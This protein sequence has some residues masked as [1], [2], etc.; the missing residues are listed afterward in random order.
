[1]AKDRKQIVRDLFTAYLNGDRKAVE[2][3]F[4]DGFQFTSPYDDRIDKAEYFKRCW[5][6]S[7]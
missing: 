4:A 5:P 3:T 6:Y 7:V 1:M 2:G